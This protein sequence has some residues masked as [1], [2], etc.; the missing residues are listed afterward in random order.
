MRILKIYSCKQCP[1]FKDYCR[2]MDRMIYEPKS[3][4]DWCP[5]DWC[6]LEEVR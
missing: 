1:H 4:P 6:S 3:I 5:L 2:L